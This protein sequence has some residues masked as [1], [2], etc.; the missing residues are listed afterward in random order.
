MND[1]FTILICLLVNFCDPV[2]THKNKQ[3]LRSLFGVDIGKFV[4]VKDLFIKKKTK[5]G[6]PFC[7]IFDILHLNWDYILVVIA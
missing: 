7:V 1:F 6:V 3:S 4:I 5:S 2:H